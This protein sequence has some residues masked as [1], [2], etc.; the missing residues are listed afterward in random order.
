MGSVPAAL[1]MLLATTV[2]LTVPSTGGGD[3]PSPAQLTDAIN[4]RVPGL[5]A[6]SIASPPASAGASGL[7]LSTTTLPEGDLRVDLFDAQGE[8]LLHRVLPAPP[9]GHD[10][11]CPAFAETVALIVERYLH[12]VGY[13]AP[14]LAPPPPKPEPPPPPP[15][16]APPMLVVAPPPPRAPRVRWRL[17]LAAMGRLGDAGGWDGDGELVV[18][19]EGAGDGPRVGARVSVGL[20][21]STEA[22]WSDQMIP[23]AATLRR[24]PL[25]LGL[26]WRIPTRAGQLE[27]GVGAGF[28]ALF[29]SSSG[30]ATPNEHHLAPFGDLSLGYTLALIGPVYLRGLSRVALAVPYDFETLGHSHV[31]GTPRVYGELG[32]ESGFAFP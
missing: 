18:G 11:D 19:L 20:A 15:A 1:A 28:D 25:R 14:P 16:P 32:V 7:S 24:F 26:Y 13:E 4:A 10:A 22:R 21:P 17:G 23:Q 30:P 12:D 8:T 9:R 31:W 6:P 2:T 3:C 29:V 27:P 5:V